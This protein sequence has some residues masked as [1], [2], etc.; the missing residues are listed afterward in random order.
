MLD[1]LLHSREP[2]L[3]EESRFRQPAMCRGRIRDLNG[4]GKASTFHRP[5]QS[6]LSNNVRRYG[7]WSC[8]VFLATTTIMSATSLRVVN[9]SEMVDSS[10]RV[11]RG[12][13][14]AVREGTLSNG[15][16]IFQY[17]FL[18]S[19]GIKGTFDGEE[20]IFRQLRTVGAGSKK[21]V[22]ILGLPTYRK[23]QEA[24]LFLAADSGIGLTSP[25]G[26][27]QGVFSVRVDD[28]GRAIVLNG[29]RNQN[30]LRDLGATRLLKMGLKNSEIVGLQARG[31]IRMK[32][33]SKAVRRI[34]AFQ[35]RRS[36]KS[37][38]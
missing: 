18:V 34:N 26:L 5:G 19:E 12:L 36:L 9:L 24:V 4:L 7:L 32:T 30:L 8:L 14:I 15:L 11:F 13:C 31:P 37:V 10:N 2:S 21:G 3:P 38:Q 28:R 1:A 27:S 33:L 16:P 17:R 29:F 22:G 25:I 6:K 35:V 20:I 23:G